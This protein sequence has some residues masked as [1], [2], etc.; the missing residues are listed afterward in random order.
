[1][2]SADGV[3]VDKS[4]TRMDTT[5]LKNRLKGEDLNVTIPE[6]TA[7]S[8]RAELAAMAAKAGRISR[9]S[10]VSRSASAVS[11][12]GSSIERDQKPVGA[13]AA[14]ISS[15]AA[16]ASQERLE[17]LK[18]MRVGAGVTDDSSDVNSASA[19]TGRRRQNVDE[20]RRRPPPA[21]KSMATRPSV[22]PSSASVRA[23]T[24]SFDHLPLKGSR[25]LTPAA[26]LRHLLQLGTANITPC[27]QRIMEKPRGQPL[28]RAAVVSSDCVEDWPDG[29]SHWNCSTQQLLRDTSSLLSHLDAQLSSL[30]S[31]V[32]RRGHTNDPTLEIQSLLSKFQE[33][34]QELSEICTSLR[35][36]GALPYTV[37]NAAADAGA[38]SRYELDNPYIGMKSSMQ[39]RRHYELLASQ[40]EMEGKERMDKLKKELEMRSVVL[41]EQVSHRK[42]FLAASGG[43]G[44]ANATGVRVRLAVS[45]EWVVRLG[46]CFRLTTRML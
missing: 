15:A 11:S 19:T 31:L 18:A 45:E 28:F 1:M 8:V 35:K 25:T 40:V 3:S 12:R 14:D 32:R 4:K 27:Q 10:S 2:D 26:P 17:R 22:S 20:I 39:R 34:A 9:E 5:H 44:C 33:G 29:N 23:R 42:K 37:D 46:Q 16:A 43:G 7:A 21:P 6:D 41:R 24:Q 30:H 13:T 38:T 36:A